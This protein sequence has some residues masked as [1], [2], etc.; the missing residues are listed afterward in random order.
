MTTIAINRTGMTNN[1]KI[2]TK[3]IASLKVEC[4]DPFI[5]TYPIV[6]ASVIRV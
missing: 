1:N 6:G 3:R 5:A 4:M 2:K